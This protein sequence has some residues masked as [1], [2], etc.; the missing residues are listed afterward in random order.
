MRALAALWSA[1]SVAVIGASERPGALGGRPVEFL[2]RYG[3]QGRVLPVHPTNE[4]VFGLPAYPK[5]AAC[6]GPVDLAMIMVAADRVPAAIE[7][8]VAAGVRAAIVCSSGFAETGAEGARRQETLV[9]QAKAGG[10]RIL[11]PN[12]IG[13]VGVASGQVTSFS[14]LFEAP[15]TRLVPG[16]LALV[17]QSGALGFGAVSLAFERGLGLGWSVSTGNE[18]EVTALEVLATLAE[19]PGCTGLLG[20]VESLADVESLRRLAAAGKPVAL[21]KAGRSAAGARAVASHTGAL[22]TDDRVTDA[23]LRRYGIVR[24][25]DVDELLDVGEAFA[26]GTRA[27]GDRVAVVTTSGGS[28][29]LA[30]DALAQHDLRLAELGAGTRAALA[31]VVPAYGSVENPVDV[32]AAVM[33]RPELFQRCLDVVA[34]DPAVDVVLACFCVLTGSDVAGIADGLT[35]VRRETGKAVLVARTGAEHLAPGAAAVLRA[36]GVPVYPTP[37][38]AVLVAAAAVRAGA[39]VAV[40]A[41]GTAGGIVAPANGI[42]EADFKE[43]LRENG[44]PVPVGRLVGSAADAV[45]AVGEVGGRAVFKAVVPG[46]VHKTEAGGVALDV[47]P[48]AAAGVYDRLAALGGAVLVE[49]FVTGAVEVLVG[50]APGPCGPMLALGLGG[51]FAEVLDDVVLAPLPVDADEVRRMVGEL[52]GSALLYGVR[53][54]VAVDV[55]A[56]VD[57]VV[58]VSSLVS[59]WGGQVDLNPVAVLPRGVRVLDA[60]YLAEGAD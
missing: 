26:A 36:G 37:G 58:R 43:L 15:S 22:A 11:G 9:A 46:L 31:E 10:L 45:A 59:G 30:A 18:A 34:A 16:S 24:V 47:D 50:V 39:R 51:I 38:R 14:P 1:R 53:G 54:R 6:P 57:L 56:L 7:D 44:I 4:T 29:I 28:G 42:S 33:A 19:E 2:L 49:E 52:R 3:Y 12:C 35:R 27:F 5:V 40:T 23:V 25:S 55:D 21:V 17:S 20:Y 41:A 32:T 60:V 13:S 8:C 48:G